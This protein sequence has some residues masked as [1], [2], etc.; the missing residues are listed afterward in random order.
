M[1]TNARAEYLFSVYQ[2]ADRRM[3][4]LAVDVADAAIDGREPWG[5]DVSHY[6]WAR[7][8][9]RIAFAMWVLEADGHFPR[10]W[11]VEPSTSS[12]APAAAAEVSP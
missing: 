5:R 4:R 8:C 10:W 6:R 3:E 9:M 2:Q 11:R 7:D 1:S 12:P